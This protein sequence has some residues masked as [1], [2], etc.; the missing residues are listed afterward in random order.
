MRVQA[1][2]N[3]GRQELVEAVRDRLL[4]SAA[5]AAENVSQSIQEG[6]VVASLKLLQSLGAMSGKVLQIPTDNPDVL[7]EESEIRE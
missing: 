2:L 1:A 5:K 6:D 3:R 4:S 7:R